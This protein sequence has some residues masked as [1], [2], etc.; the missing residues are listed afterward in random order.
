MVYYL[1]IDGGATKTEA[2]IINDNL[3][4]LGYS[5]TGPSNYHTVG[6]DK[7]IE[8]I[9]K[10]IVN[11]SKIAN[12]E[13]IFSAACIALA[14]INSNLDYKFLLKNLTNLNFFTK[15]MLIH[16]G[17]AALYCTTYGKKGIIVIVG[18]GSLVAGYDD[19]GKYYRTCNWGHILGDEGSGYRI[20]L[21]VLRAIIKGYDGRESIP[22]ITYEIAKK[23]KIKSLDE[24]S[25]LVHTR[26][27]NEEIA[28]LA[29]LAIKYAEKDEKIYNILKEEANEI[30]KCVE[31][32]YK[33]IRGGD[34]YLTG[35]IILSKKN[36]IY[37][38]MIKEEIKK[39]INT[40]V[41]ETK[42]SP[43]IGSLIYLMQKENIILNK[44]II[45]NIYKEYTKIK[46]YYNNLN[47]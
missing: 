30:A 40:N 45:K 35:G 22:L 8:N 5:K 32:I 13:P 36:K 44:N 9:I 46:K 38:E 27:S 15:L 19:E 2:V 47:K 7:A 23:F 26:L 41:Y 10:A 39:R 3:K 29:P 17:E 6:I 28:S 16:D 24:I 43:V 42:I 18:T 4:V 33:K 14:A 31:T 1:A 20:G 34:V 21:K 11:A 25:T 37:I 12:I